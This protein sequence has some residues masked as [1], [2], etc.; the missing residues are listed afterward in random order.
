MYTPAPTSLPTKKRK[1]TK[2]VGK[3]TS[4][5]KKSCTAPATSSHTKGKAVAV[6]SQLSIHNLEQ[7]AAQPSSAE[8]SVMAKFPIHTSSVAKSLFSPL[9]SQVHSSPCTPQQCHPVEQPAAYQTERTSSYMVA[10]AHSQAQQDIASSPLKSTTHKT[11]KR[12]HVKGKLNFD[13]TDAGQGSNEQVCEK[14]ST[15]SDGDKQDDFEINFTNLDIFDGE[16]SFSEL[17]SYILFGFILHQCG[18]LFYYF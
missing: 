4:S 6:N 2:S 14:A 3:T 13:S 18:A 11:S 5:S 15:S 9:Q 7:N 1:A 12:E 10:N 8:H 16:F 17:P